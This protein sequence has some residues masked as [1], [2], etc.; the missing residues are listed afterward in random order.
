MEKKPGKPESPASQ[1]EAMLKFAKRERL[2][3][4]KEAGEIA[5]MFINSEDAT[6][7]L[8]D[9]L[10]ELASVDS[11]VSCDQFADAVRM[12]A[13]GFPLSVEQK[14]EMNNFTYGLMES[15]G[16]SVGPNGFVDLSSLNK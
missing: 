7:D 9:R 3:G 2:S 15:F 11:R 12:C 13:S 1:L 4:Y 8:A 6:R 14:R 5:D 16:G 10:V